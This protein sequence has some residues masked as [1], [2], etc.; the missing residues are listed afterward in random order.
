MNKQSSREAVASFLNF[1]FLPVVL[2]VSTLLVLAPAVARAQI[3]P[4]GD[5]YTNSAD[6][7]TN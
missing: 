2:A 1:R 6:P 5:A 3:T 4:L 7:T